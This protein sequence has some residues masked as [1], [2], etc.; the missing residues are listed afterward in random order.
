MIVIIKL[1]GLSRVSGFSIG[2]HIIAVS[3]IL[4]AIDVRYVPTG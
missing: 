1:L 2:R 3:I 4:L